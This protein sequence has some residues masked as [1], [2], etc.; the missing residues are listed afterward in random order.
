MEENTSAEDRP[1]ET[2]VDEIALYLCQ[3]GGSPSDD[4][5]VV[6]IEKHLYREQAEELYNRGLRSAPKVRRNP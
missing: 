4:L 2:V 1:K 6:A 5:E 3:L